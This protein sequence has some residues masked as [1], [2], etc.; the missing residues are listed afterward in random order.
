MIDAALLL[1]GLFTVV[2]QAIVGTQANDAAKHLCLTGIKKL[3]QNGKVVNHDL[4]KALKTS[5]LKAQQQIASECHKEL[6]EPSRRASKGIVIYLPQHRPY[7]EWLDKKIKQLKSELEKVDKE[8]VPSGIP[9]AGL[10]EIELLLTATDELKQNR[11]EAVKQKLL[12][13][14]LENCDVTLYKTKLEQDLLP[15]VA[16]YFAQE[17]KENEKVFQ[18]F[19]GQTLTRIDIRTQEMYAWLEEIVEKSRI[20]YVPIDWEAICQQILYEKE[21]QRLSSNQLTFGKHQIDDVYVPLGLVERQKVTQRREDVAAEEGSDLYREKEVTQTFEHSEFLEQVLRQGSSPKSNGKRLGIIGEPGAGKT[22]LL[23]QI[24]NWVAAEISEA[25]VIWVSLADLQRKELEAYLF[26]NWL[27]AAIKRIGKA[28]A[29]AEIKDDFLAQFNAE[30]VWLVLDGADEM[31]VGDGNPLTEIQRQIRTGGCIQRARIVL[32][33][34]QNVWDAIG[35]ALDTFDTYRTLEFSYPEQVEM[36]IDKWFGTPRG[37]HGGTAPTDILDVGAVPP[38]PP[39]AV[40]DLAQQLREA[41]AA[42]GK[43]RIQDLVK[44][45]LRCSLL[46]GTWQSLDGDL[47]DTKAKLY[48]RFVT[49]LYQWKKPRLNWIQQQDLNAALGKLALAGML[50]ETDRF[51]LPESVGYGVMGESQFELACRLGWLNLVARDGETAEGI[52]AFYHPTFQEYFAALAV[53]DWHFFLNH[54]PKNP[55]HPDARYRIFEKQWKEVI[56]LWLGR[57]EVGKEEKE[58][59]IKA[60][61]KFKVGW[62]KFY[63]YRAYFLAAEGI[64]EFKDCSL[65]D[66]IVSQIVI[67]GFGYFNKQKQEWR[68]FLDPIVDRAR[69]V[70]KET[71]R[72]R[73]IFALVELIRNCG[74]EYTRRE[75]TRSLGEIAKNCP[76]TIA[77]LVELINTS[78]DEVT[79]WQAA[80]I[81]G[82]IDKD[83]PIAISAL[84]E[85]IHTSVEKNT[86]KRAAYSLGTIGKDSPEAIAALVELIRNSVEN[87]FYPVFGWNHVPTCIIV[88]YSLVKIGKNN[89]V[90][91]AALVELIRTSDNKV[92]QGRAAEILGKIDND[93]PVAIETLLDSIRNYRPKDNRYQA[94]ERLATIGKSNPVA[95]AAL[96]ELISTSRNQV[97]R[98]RAAECLGKIDKG[99]TVAISA[100]GDLIRNSNNKITQS[101][102]A[103]SL[104]KIGKD[105]PEAI[106]LLVDF[107]CNSG[108]EFTR[109]LAAGSLGEIGKDTPEAISALVDLI[110]NSQKEETR[111]QAAESLGKIGKDSPEAISAL[112]ELIRTS[113]KEETRRQ[114]AASLGTIGKDSPEAISALVELIRTSQNES[115]RWRAANSLGKTG[116]EQ[117]LAS[118]TLVELIGTCHD[119]SFVESNSLWTIGKDQPVAIFGLVELIRN[120]GDEYTRRSAALMLG[121]IGKDY[122]EVISALQELI[123]NSRELDTRCVAAYSLGK[124]DIGNSVAIAALVE[125]IRKSRPEDTMYDPAGCLGKIMTGKH[126]AT[127]VSGLKKC[128]TSEIYK[129]NFGRNEKCYRLIWNCAENMTYPEFYP[130]WHA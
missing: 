80:D 54:F 36:L 62:D 33:C 27:L 37:G 46:C 123:R 3:S 106:S 22:T 88:A 130:A 87:G 56:L 107:I 51:Q 6:V 100:L 85:L 103:T 61:V 96:V 19:T 125:L 68:T 120:C 110:A 89:P 41:L 35:S 17:I 18:I 129:N 28:E 116:K 84:A 13:V 26:D 92:T 12:E 114:A 99:N 111:Q 77:A 63:G 122:P 64:A 108:D 102:A 117:Q 90:A 79:R 38:C 48:R 60:L 5:F 121:A 2:W 109:R 11:V 94:A 20:A 10:D 71:D 91:I 76:D 34:R 55:Q 70:L 74:D 47:P 58:A 43:E 86:W 78:Q 115:T 82:K 101:S 83:S 104:N 75:A 8:T 7:L 1:G 32:S 21:Q 29:T 124:I 42:S 119:D 16:A 15:L 67:W 128:L 49:T 31:A 98:W 53:E 72:K 73:A 97:T 66:E 50:N 95:I 69:E 14:A 30:R 113:Y 93:N 126:F 65:A 24:A 59:F 9:I 23:R 105:S 45:P 52:Y 44:N 127:A 39:S 57:E 4:E 118:S 81:L 112:V 25:I 40:G